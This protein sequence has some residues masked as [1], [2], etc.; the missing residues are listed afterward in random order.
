MTDKLLVFVVGFVIACAGT[1]FVV[2]SLPVA[3][4]YSAMYARLPGRMQLAS[5]WPKVFGFALLGF[6]LLFVVLAIAAVR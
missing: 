2:F 3:R 6:G 1:L 4:A 5:W